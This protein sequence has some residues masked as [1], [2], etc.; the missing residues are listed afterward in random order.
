MGL[1]PAKESASERLTYRSKN[2]DRVRARVRLRV[3]ARVRLRVRARVRVSSKSLP[4]R[5]ARARCREVQG[6]CMVGAWYG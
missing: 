5:E 3:R 4:P 1:P 6:R 2:L